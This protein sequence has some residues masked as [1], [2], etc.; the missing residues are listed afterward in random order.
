M[1]SLLVG[2]RCYLCKETTIMVTELAVTSGL[3]SSLD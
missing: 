3:G 1:K 2:T